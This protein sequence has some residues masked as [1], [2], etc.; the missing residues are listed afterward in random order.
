ML[1]PLLTADELAAYLKCSRR[2]L[3]DMKL[4]QPIYVGRL[5]RWRSSDISEWVRQQCVNDSESRASA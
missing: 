4:P 1:D 5:P 3:Y 2:Q